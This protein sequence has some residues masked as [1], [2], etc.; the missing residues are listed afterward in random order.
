MSLKRA[1]L[2]GAI[3]FVA[4]ITLLQ[5]FI[6]QGGGPGSDKAE[7]AGEKFRVGHLPV[8]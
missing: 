3:V 5:I 7:Q 6:K 1:L 2:L 4:G 8:T